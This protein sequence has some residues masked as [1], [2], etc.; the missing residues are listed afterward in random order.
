MDE[1]TKA[2][3]LEYIGKQYQDKTKLDLALGHF[4]KRIVRQKQKAE[5]ADS[6]GVKEAEDGLDKYF[7][8]EDDSS[9]ENCS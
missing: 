2:R 6:M 5:K 1:L 9:E 7:D 3:S 4:K 8:D